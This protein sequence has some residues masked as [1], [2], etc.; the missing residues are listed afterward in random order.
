MRTVS[1]RHYDEGAVSSLTVLENPAVERSAEVLFEV[2]PGLQHALTPLTDEYLSGLGQS[3]IDEI[4][5]AK[6]GL[7]KDLTAKLRLEITGTSSMRHEFVLGEPAMP[8]VDFL[9]EMTSYC[10]AVEELLDDA[11][12][13]MGSHLGVPSNAV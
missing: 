4:T 2:R 12:R 11:D 1:E 9:A 6:V 7:M 3:E 13:A 10:D 8:F 5:R